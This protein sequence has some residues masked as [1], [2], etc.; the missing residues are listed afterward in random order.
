MPDDSDDDVS[1]KYEIKCYGR[2]AILD[3]NNVRVGLATLWPGDVVRCP[4]GHKIIFVERL[5][6]AEKQPT[7]SR[8]TEDN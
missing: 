3:D 4:S 8:K 6:E 2:Y 5:T 7:R 1:E